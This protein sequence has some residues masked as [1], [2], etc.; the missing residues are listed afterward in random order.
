MNEFQRNIE[1]NI[2]KIIEESRKALCENEKCGA[3]KLK[4]YYIGKIENRSPDIHFRT[5]VEFVSVLDKKDNSHYYEEGKEKFPDVMRAR[6]EP[7]SPHACRKAI[8]IKEFGNEFYDLL[9][10]S[11]DSK[12]MEIAKTKLE[13]VVMWAVKAACIDG[14][15]GDS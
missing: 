3:C 4:R 2:K 5:I 6:S 12:E 7:T 8:E 14:E 11:S 9:D 1:D 10:N 15:R 13:E